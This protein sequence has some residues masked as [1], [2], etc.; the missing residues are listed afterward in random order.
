MSEVMAAA[1]DSFPEGVVSEVEA[2]LVE[3]FLLVS[4]PNEVLMVGEDPL[5][6]RNIPRDQEAAAAQGR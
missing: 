1:G 3:S 4:I 5:Q 6:P 2:D